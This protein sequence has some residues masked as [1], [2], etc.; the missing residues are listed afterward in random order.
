MTSDLRIQA[1]VVVNSEQ[2]ES[3]FNRVGDKAQQMANTVATSAGKAGQ[4]VDGMGDSA[5]KSA[6][7]FTRAD[8]LMHAAIMK[9]TRE[10]ELLGKTASQRFE[11][12]M[13][14]KGLEK[15]KFQEAIS[16]LQAMESALSAA[17]AREAEFAAQ[18]AF[19]LKAAQA[20]ELV[21]ASEYARWWAQE[22]EKVE[23][24]EK[25]LAG[26]NSFIASLKSQ[27]DAIGKT[28]ADLLEMQAAQMGVATQAAPFIARMREA[29]AG[30]G[31]MGISA[32][33]TAAALRGV[34]AQFPTYSTSGRVGEREGSAALA[35][36]ESDSCH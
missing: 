28:K 36:S 1:D 17:K 18:N 25:R 15:A 33:Q 5:E 23:A 7:K 35:S 21:K 31:K 20:K 29:E 14:F 13:D 16:G 22:L 32:A 9:S 10:L 11:A 2:A 6:E 3:A 12:Q 19:S 26:Q 30:V 24:A 4:A 34:P 27:A 8:S